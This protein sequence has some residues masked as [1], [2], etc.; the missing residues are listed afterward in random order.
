MAQNALTEILKIDSANREEYIANHREL[1]KDLMILNDQM[2]DMFKDSKGMSFFVY[3]PAWGYFAQR[4]GLNQIAI[5]VDGKEPS[6][7]EM[8]KTVQLIK[9][10]DVKKIFIQEQFSDSVVKSIAEETG[11]TPV[12]IDPLEENVIESIRKSASLIKEGLVK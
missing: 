11:I 8:A 10:K 6:A 5:E 4:Y 9:E 1:V 7:S 2:A 12:L 3:H